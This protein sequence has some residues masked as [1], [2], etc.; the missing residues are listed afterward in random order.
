MKK[1]ITLSIFAFFLTFSVQT[2]AQF[3]HPVKLPNASQKAKVYQQVG[4][5]DITIVYHR[6]LVKGR[7]VF[8][9]MV[10]FGKVW[11]TGA[12]EN[13]VIKFSTDVTINGKEL[14]A[15]KYGF[16]AIPN[17]D[18]WTL[19]F[20]KDNESWGSY[21]YNQERDALRVDVAA[22]STEHNELLTYS[23]TDVS[24]DAA[25]VNLA[26]DKTMVSFTV[27]AKTKDLAVASLKRQINSLP[28]WGWTGLYNAANYTLTNNTHLEDGLTWI[29]RSVQNNK[30]FTNLMLKSQ[31]LEKLNKSAEAQPLIAEA[32]EMGTINQI[33]R[34]AYFKFQAK[35]NAAGINALKHNI[36][37][38]PKNY[39]S[40][41]AMAWGYT[42]AGD[43]KEAMKMYKK[44][45]KMAPKDKTANIE[46][47]MA[48]LK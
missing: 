38:N 28:F 45:L 3:E 18:N 13:T 40:Y 34:Y 22:T 31:I 4:V 10:P 15:G 39:Q 44:A 11:R 19:I 6:P 27:K 46:K 36:K 32:F 42:N 43:K 8:G 33:N 23:F 9:K 26:W 47:A 41:T 30:N 37:N 2:H 1:L 35:D 7:E 29:N 16:H 24:S 5:T 21:F 12:N 20:N 48:A 25:T 17:K 14:K